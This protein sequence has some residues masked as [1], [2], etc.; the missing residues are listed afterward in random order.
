MKTDDEW[1]NTVAYTIYLPASGKKNLI[2]QFPLST[3]D[4]DDDDDAGDA[5]YRGR[6]LHCRLNFIILL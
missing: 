4:D 5:I 3:D 6:R 1:R 2:I